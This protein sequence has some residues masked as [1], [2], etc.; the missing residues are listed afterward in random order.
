MIDRRCCGPTVG[1]SWAARLRSLRVHG[2]SYRSRR[3]RR[4]AFAYTRHGEVRSVRG[5]P[6]ARVCRHAG[7]TR[8]NSG[9]AVEWRG[10]CCRRS[11]SASPRRQGGYARVRFGNRMRRLPARRR[12]GLLQAR[13]WSSRIRTARRMSLPTCTCA[14]ARPGSRSDARTTRPDCGQTTT[15]SPR[16]RSGCSR[17]RA[18]PTRRL[19]CG[20]L[21]RMI[22]DAATP[23]DAEQLRRGHEILDRSCK[24]LG[25]FPCRVLALEIEDSRFGPPDAATVSVLLARACHRRSQRVRISAQR[26][27]HVPRA[28][29]RQR[30]GGLE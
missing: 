17:S 5:D 16:A 3:S 14:P 21:G 13:G 10:V 2:A 22:V 8:T 28:A 12:G 30:L 24:R 6:G 9:G 23:V 26:R 29:V 11:G 27:E 15:P 1:R 4:P 7:D 19:G 18:R 25:R 20:M